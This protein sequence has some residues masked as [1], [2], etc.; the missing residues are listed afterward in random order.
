MLTPEI[1]NREVR[2]VDVCSAKGEREVD[3]GSEIGTEGD[4]D[5]GMWA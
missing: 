5:A 4:L 1:E 2:E 3:V